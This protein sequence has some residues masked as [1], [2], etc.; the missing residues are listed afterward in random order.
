MKAK[1]T[2]TI[3]Y[4][5]ADGQENAIDLMLGH[6]A[7]NLAD[8]GLLSGDFE[9][10]DISHG[11]EFEEEVAPTPSIQNEHLES[12][13]S[14]VLTHEK[15]DFEDQLGQCIESFD[16]SNTEKFNKVMYDYIETLS[17]D[18][19]VLKW[20]AF[21]GN[22]HVYCDA[23]RA[24]AAAKEAPTSIEP[25]HND[26][27]DKFIE[28]VKVESLQDEI[29]QEII[30]RFLAYEEEAALSFPIETPTPSEIKL[31]LIDASLDDE[32]SGKLSTTIKTEN[33][34]I[35]IYPEGYGHCEMDDG[36]GY[37]VFI[38]F[39]EGQL[40]VGIYPDIFEPNAQIIDMSGAKESL[41]KDD[42]K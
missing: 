38:E 17:T 22:N 40:R 29:P 25:T 27:I 11:V 32:H 18:E 5:G 36:S 3:D 2:I 8:N 21:N 24:V 10:G 12:V 33:G 35:S 37:P 23:V 41:R 1:L 20:L 7:E 9:T 4:P 39:Y 16:E 26:R 14:Y 28:A 19:E 34:F 6:A 13:L 31:D 15:S 30:A 42:T